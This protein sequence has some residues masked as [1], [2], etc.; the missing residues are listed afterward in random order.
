MVETNEQKFY[1]WWENRIPDRTFVMGE[2]KMVRKFR[3][4]GNNGRK[5]LIGG[6][7]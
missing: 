3:F 1:G 4:V 7:T 6:K 5:I 2:K